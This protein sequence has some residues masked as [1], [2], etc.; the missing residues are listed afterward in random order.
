MA[1]EVNINIQIHMGVEN[2]SEKARL[3][4]TVFP[5]WK[6]AVVKKMPRPTSKAVRWPISV[7][8]RDIKESLLYSPILVD[9]LVKAVIKIMDSN[10][11]QIKE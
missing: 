7:L 4:P 8:I 11:T 1:R 9:M 5:A 3:A 2:N 6:E 10:R